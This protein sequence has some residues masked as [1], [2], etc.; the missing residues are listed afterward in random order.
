MQK[1]ILSAVLG[2][3]ATL[4]VASSASAL[5]CK[6][7]ATGCTNGQTKTVCCN[8][9]ELTD[10]SGAATPSGAC[11]SVTLAGTNVIGGNADASGAAGCLDDALSVTAAGPAAGC[12][13]VAVDACVQGGCVTESACHN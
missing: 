13:D 12:G 2:C 10:P 5:Y 9:A 11:G 1:L 8:N 7:V 4:V 3:A 6:E